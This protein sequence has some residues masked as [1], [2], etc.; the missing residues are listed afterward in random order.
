[1]TYNEQVCHLFHRGRYSKGRP[2]F[3]SKYYLLLWRIRTI[4]C[5]IIILIQQ[6]G[7]TTWLTQT[8]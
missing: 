2:F 8:N 1:M 7:E 3:I 6:G 5:G 4:Q